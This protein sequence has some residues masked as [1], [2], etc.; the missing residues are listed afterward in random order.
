MEKVVRAQEE[1]SYSILEENGGRDLGEEL[2]V[3]WWNNR[4]RSYYPPLDYICEPWMTAVMDTVAPY[5]KIETIYWEMKKGVEE[6]FREWNAI[7]HAH[8]SHWYD[9]GTSFYPTFLVKDFP[10][11]PHDSV[12]LYNQI[13]EICVRAS[14][15]NGGVVN[16]HHGIGL[17]FG[18][19]MKEIYGE[20]YD[21]AQIIK[22]ALDPDFLLNPGKLGLGE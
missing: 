5:E 15:Q 7:F 4:Y 20:S 9:W 21:L 16:E 13:L 1:V 18:R 11:D 14:L 12:R 19:F 2:A 3:N 6:G 22:T 17:R 8:F 10:S